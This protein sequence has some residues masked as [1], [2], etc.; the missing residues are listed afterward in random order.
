METPKVSHWDYLI[1][2]AKYYRSDRYTQE[3][4]GQAFCNDFN[5]TNPILF[6]VEQGPRAEKI[7]MEEYIEDFR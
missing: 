1:W 6:N 2:R 3:R 4:L 5:V 7:I